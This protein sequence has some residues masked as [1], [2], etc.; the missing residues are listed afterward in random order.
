MEMFFIINNTLSFPNKASMTSKRQI[1]CYKN[2]NFDNGLNFKKLCGESGSAE[3]SSANERK[4]EKLKFSLSKYTE[5]E[6]F[7]A[8]VTDLFYKISPEKNFSLQRIL[9][10]WR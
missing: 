4:E 9:M 6:I 5:E 7:I 1:V 10:H 8:Y 2:L 3:A